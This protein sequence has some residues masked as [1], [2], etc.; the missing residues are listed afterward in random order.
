[1]LLLSV[2]RIAQLYSHMASRI[3]F[4]YISTNWRKSYFEN[5]VKTTDDLLPRENQA[6]WSRTVLL[7]LLHRDA[8]TGVHDGGTGP[9][10]LKGGN[11]ATASWVGNFGDAGERWNDRIISLLPLKGGKRGRRCLFI[12][13]SL[14]ILW[15]IKID[16]KQIHCSSSRTHNIQNGFL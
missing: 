11:G 14:V 4:V 12:T 6:L 15:Y 8:G 2:Q 7:V 13:E 10:S 1:V 9:C 16:L 3:T 5:Y